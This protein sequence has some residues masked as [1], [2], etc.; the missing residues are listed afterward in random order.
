MAIDPDS[1]RA[2]SYLAEVKVQPT[3]LG[4]THAATQIGETEQASADRCPKALGTRVKV[5]E[6][7]FHHEVTN[8]FLW[9]L[10]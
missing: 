10:F 5:A 1:A 6:I 2:C 7:Q 4:E 3:R 8:Q 9:S